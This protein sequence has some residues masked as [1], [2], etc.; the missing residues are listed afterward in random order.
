M[1]FSGYTSDATAPTIAIGANIE[2]SITIKLTDNKSPATFNPY[3]IKLVVNN[4]NRKPVLDS[5]HS[6]ILSTTWVANR[7]ALNTAV[8]IESSWWNDA[9]SDTVT[10]TCEMVDSTQNYM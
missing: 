7:N 5:S 9:D 1:K 8:N 3:T 10:I 6:L 2:F 4:L